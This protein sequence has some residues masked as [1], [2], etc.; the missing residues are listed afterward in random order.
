MIR[1]NQH[2]E[3]AMQPILILTRLKT[4]CCTWYQNI[5]HNANGKCERCK[6]KDCTDRDWRILGKNMPSKF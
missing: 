5:Q 2:S 1:R 4:N 6:A 3:G